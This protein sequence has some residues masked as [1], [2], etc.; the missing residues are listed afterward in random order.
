[1]VMY[2]IIWTSMCERKDCAMLGAFIVQV[3]LNALALI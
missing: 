2:N 1:M 3:Q